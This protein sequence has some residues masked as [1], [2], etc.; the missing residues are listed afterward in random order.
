MNQAGRGLRLDRLSDVKELSVIAL[1]Y[2][3]FLLLV[4]SIRRISPSSVSAVRL[5]REP[6]G[7][8]YL[9][10]LTVVLL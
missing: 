9:L 8:R 10:A 2:T 1:I 7:L 3:N 6:S 5:L 4:F